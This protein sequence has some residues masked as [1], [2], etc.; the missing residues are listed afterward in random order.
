MVFEGIITIF[1]R[2]VKS[3]S[4]ICRIFL[5]CENDQ[6]NAVFF[7]LFREIAQPTLTRNEGHGI[8]KY[9]I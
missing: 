5:L 4:A 7:G 3:F 2:I 1:G 9:I 6:I 8:I